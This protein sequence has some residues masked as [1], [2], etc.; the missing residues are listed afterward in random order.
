[1]PILAAVVLF[2]LFLYGCAGKTI[3]Q[4]PEGNDHHPGNRAPLLP[5]P[6]IKLPPGS[7]R[8][9]GWLRHQL[10]A[11][12]EGFVGHLP[13]VSPWCRFEENAWTD[14]EG[15]GEHGWE[16]VPYWLKGFI[17]LGYALDDERILTESRRWVDAVLS[18]QRDNG[19]FGPETNLYI[20]GKLAVEGKLPEDADPNKTDL[21]PNMAMLYALRTHYEATGDERVL[22][23]ML[24]Y[25]RWMRAVPLEHLLSQSW[26]QLRAGDSLD[27]LYWLY[28]RTGEAWLLELARTNHEL[29]APWATGI[30]SWHGVNICQ[31]FREPAQYYQ[32]T[33]DPRYLQATERNYETV[34]NRFGQVPGGMFGADENARLGHYGP[35][36]A[37][38][39]C[40]MV[41]MMHSHEML[42]GITGEARWADRC[43]EVTFNS[44]P[45]ALTPDL[46]GL[47]YLRACCTNPL[48]TDEV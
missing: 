11:M 4:A 8:P 14:P 36:Q 26:Q 15:K 40:S 6:L 41:E 47:H 10:E 31:G 18:T 35:R 16:E 21:W 39:T 19:Y 45:A 25:F 17:S 20:D 38:E 42:L 28:N 2:L 13:E 12:A 37:A 29:T 43:E 33:L 23:F 27:S 5:S 7:I 9:E 3:G 30:P 34:M 22:S 44:L 48:L 24:D 46:K 1:M 32:Q